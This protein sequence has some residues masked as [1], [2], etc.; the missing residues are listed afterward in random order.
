MV[1]GR[2]VHH[3]HSRISL[4]GQLYSTPEPMGCPASFVARNPR[5]GGRC[6]LPKEG[7]YSCL[8]AFHSVGIDP[9][10][11]QK[12]KDLW[13][14]LCASE[15]CR[16]RAHKGTWSRMIVDTF[17]VSFHKVGC[18]LYTLWQFGHLCSGAACFTCDLSSSV[19]RTCM[20]PHG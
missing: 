6:M 4:L 7:L 13:G 3:S 18:C 10:L 11:F 1:R 2:W 9:N 14:K 5:E 17:S 19:P 12:A 20:F 8:L 16:S 15:P